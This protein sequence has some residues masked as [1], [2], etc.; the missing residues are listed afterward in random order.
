MISPA[1]TSPGINKKGYK[2]VFCQI[3]S[4]EKIGKA[5]A[6]YAAQKATKVVIY[7]ADD[8]YGRG[9]ANSFEDNAK[10]NGVKVVD[11][12]TEFGE[13]QYFRI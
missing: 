1:S 8:E 4:D 10:A 9:L 7:Y 13:G 6:E 12:V 11:R 3:P 5:M 2:Y